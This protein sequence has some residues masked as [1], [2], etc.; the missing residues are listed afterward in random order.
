MPAYKDKKRN[1]WY[2]K[3][4]IKV[5]GKPKQILKRGFA[6]KRDAQ[7]YE[8]RTRYSA[9]ASGMTFRELMQRYLDY[10]KPKESTTEL[11]ERLLALHFPLMDQKAADITKAQLMD[12]YIALPSEL[13]AST[14]NT[15]LV[16]VKA[17]YKYGAAFY[18]MPNPAYHLRRFKNKSKEM[19]VWSIEEFTQFISVVDNDV[20]RAFFSFLYWAGARK[21]EA[22]ALR[23]TDF[24]G[25]V[26]H[27][28]QQWNEHGF[29]D[30]KSDY[31]ERT[32]LLPDTLQ[33]VLQPVLAHCNETRP[34]V[35]GGY[36]P[37][38]KTALRYWW[39]RS[40]K[41][42]GVKRIRMHDLRH[43]F[44]TNM[45]CNGANIVAVSKYLGHSSIDI[46]LKTYTHLLENTN[47]EMVHLADK[48]M[49]K[50]TKNVS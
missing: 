12:W 13:S 47:A 46:T 29:S 18:D 45:I 7:E 8:S 24:H 2:V 35:F 14:K 20:Y 11:Y 30:L 33:A 38:S 10:K 28:H 40:I 36:E 27:M 19:Q 43:S 9:S 50:C 1:T 22:Q 23:Y 42:S 5:D 6:T 44:A 32:L 15:V 16:V 17:V 34:F 25:N 37:I 39:E 41:L 4:S 31:S 26:V 3:Y 21:S 49:Q 48:M